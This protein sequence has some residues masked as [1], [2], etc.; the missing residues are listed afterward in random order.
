MPCL[1][2]MGLYVPLYSYLADCLVL[3]VSST[4]YWNFHK[5]VKYIDVIKQHRVQFGSFTF[6]TKSQQNMIFTIPSVCPLNVCTNKQCLYSKSNARLMGLR[7]MLTSAM[8]PEMLRILRLSSL[9]LSFTLRIPRPSLC[10][11]VVQ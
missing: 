4:F 5:M 9:F 1:S 7:L 8:L 11:Y 2:F 10:L 6:P 3:Q